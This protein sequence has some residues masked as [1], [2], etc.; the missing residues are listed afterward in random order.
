ME[1][2]IM[3]NIL[4]I[5]AVNE[6]DLFLFWRQRCIVSDIYEFGVNRVQ[7]ASSCSDCKGKTE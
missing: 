2:L 4:S 1:N 3:E 7:K 5:L 6:P